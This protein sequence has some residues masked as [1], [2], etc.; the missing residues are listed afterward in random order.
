MAKKIKVDPA[1]SKPPKSAAAIR[2]GMKNP[3]AI[4]AINRGLAALTAE[5]IEGQPSA[6]IVPVW[7]A[8]HRLSSRRP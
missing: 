6:D 4:A 8:E 2:A 7:M 3:I 1:K 5:R